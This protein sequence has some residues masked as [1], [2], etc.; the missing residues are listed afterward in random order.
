MNTAQIVLLALAFLAGTLGSY[1]VMRIFSTRHESIR[2]TFASVASPDPQASG[3]GGALL[4]GIRRILHGMGRILSGSA[5][6]ED[7]PQRTRFLR[8]GLRGATVPAAYYGLKL[9]LAGAVPGLAC[10]R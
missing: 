5:S 6:R 8:A 4:D 3:Q 10:H 1:A 9:L 7:S 2:I